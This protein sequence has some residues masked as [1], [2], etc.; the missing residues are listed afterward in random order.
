MTEIVDAPHGQ[1]R[2]YVW[3]PRGNYLAFSYATTIRNGFQPI[4]IWSAADGKV[5]RVTDEMFNALQSGLGSA[6][7]LSLLPQRPR[8]CAADFATSN[9]T[10]PRIADSYIYAMALRKDVK[11]PFPPESDEV[12]VTKPRST[13]PQGLRRR[14]AEA[15]AKDINKELKEPPKP[16]TLPATGAAPLGDRT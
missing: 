10:T 4:Y 7:K 3:S 11:H 14:R 9:S 2:D 6:G 12:T 1:I 16:G 15:A 5:H 13:K 8:I